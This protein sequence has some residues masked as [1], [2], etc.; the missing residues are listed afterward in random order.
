MCVFPDENTEKLFDAA[1]KTTTEHDLIMDFA[2]GPNQGQ[3]VPAT[4]GDDGIMVDLRLSESSIDINGTFNDTLPG[5]GS[6]K[7]QAA[8][9]AVVT[10]SENSSASAPSLPNDLPASRL[11]VTL[12]AKSIQVITDKVGSDGHLDMSFGSSTEEG[13]GR[14]IFGVYFYEYDAYNQAQ[15]TSLL[16]PQTPPKNFIQNGSLTADHF[17]SHGAKLITDFWEKY[18]L[19]DG[20]KE[21]LMKVG[22]Y[23]WEDSIEINPDLYWTTD[24]PENF[25]KDHGYSIDKW[26]PLMFHQNSLIEH[27]NTWYITDEPDSGN[28]HIGDYRTTVRREIFQ[29]QDL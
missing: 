21:A 29:Y 4:P 25:E 19:I 20:T 17:S 11:Q 16:G 3:G 6:G 13:T 10:K 12:S 28:S 26:Y 18:L 1:I 22:N 9:T 14:L 5:W 24:L 27:Y 8:L 7:L 23:A 15:P 2:M